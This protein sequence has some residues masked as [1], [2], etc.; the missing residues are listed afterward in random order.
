[1]QNNQYEYQHMLELSLI[2]KYLTL[3]EALDNDYIVKQFLLSY[4]TERLDQFIYNVYNNTPDKIIIADYGIDSP[5]YSILQYIGNYIILTEK[6]FLDEEP[7]YHTYYG[8]K[9][10]Q[11]LGEKYNSSILYYYLITLDNL[12]LQI[13]NVR[14][15]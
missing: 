11:Q 10:K 9:I 3:E 6:S 2:P 14:L 13:F 1:M 12:E 5:S 4:N 8:N 15:M 7:R